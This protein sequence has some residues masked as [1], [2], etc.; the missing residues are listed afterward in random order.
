MWSVLDDH[1]ASALITEHIGLLITNRDLLDLRLCLLNRFLEIRVEVLDDRLPLR[2]TRRDTVEQGFHVRGERSIDDGRE[3][4]LHHIVNG[5][6]E[7]GNEDVLLFLRDV[8]AGQQGTDGRCISRRTTDAVLLEGLYEGRLGI[9]CRRL[10]EVLFLIEAVERKGL[11]DRKLRKGNILLRLIFFRHV[12][13]EETI[14]AE[15]RAVQ[16]EDILSGT[17]LH[18]FG[19]VKCSRHTAREEALIDQLVQTELVARELLLRFFRTE[20][21]AGRTDRLVRVLNLHFGLGLRLCA[22]A[23]VHIVLAELCGDEASGSRIR[24]VGDT[25]TVGTKVGDK[26][27][28][29]QGLCEL[30]GLAGS[31]A[32]GLRSLLL[33]R[34]GRKWQ[35]CLLATLGLPDITHD[36][37]GLSNL[38]KDRIDLCL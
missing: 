14:E 2:P 27:I 23:T 33:H 35:R 25:C 10:C 6:T 22:G 31:E 28:L 32:E 11:A 16:C 20:I 26:T 13:R 29:I 15:L 24:L 38:L 37:I 36:E 21:E 8:T 4:L 5:E 18:G 30:H 7:L 1:V 17:E 19:A 12:N 34:R 9:V 3:V